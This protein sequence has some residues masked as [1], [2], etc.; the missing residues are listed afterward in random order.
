MAAA[1]AATLLYRTGQPM[2]HDYR[3]LTGTGEPNTN[4][5]GQVGWRYWDSTDT[6]WWTCITA[7]NPGT[8]A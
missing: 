6:M 2:P 7:G 8:W 1:T 3:I 5:A 4:I